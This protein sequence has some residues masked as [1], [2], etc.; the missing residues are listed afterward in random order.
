MH[1]LVTGG[2]GFI[3]SHIVNYY[4]SVSCR[5]TIIDNLSTGT[6]DNISPKA[7]FINKDITEDSW[8]DLLPKDITH[9]IHL[10]AQSSGEISFEDPLY[11]I[12][13][14]A[15]ATLELLNWSLNNKVQKFIFASSMNIYGDVNDELI[16]EDYSINP[17]SF[18]GVGKA[19]SERYIKIFSELGLD[20]VILRLFNIYGPGQNMQ[21]MK[22]GMLSIYCSYVAN[23]DV[24]IVKGSE[25]RFRDFVYIDDV[26]NAV[27]L[28]LRSQIKFDTFNISTGIRTT[29]REALN[30]IFE[31]FDC[32][33]Y[34]Y[35][36]HGG[37]PRD[38]F[39]IY[40]SFEKINKSLGWSPDHNLTIGL[41][42]MIAWL[43]NE[44]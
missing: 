17:T 40:G 8:T 30:K 29:V 34:P 14:N 2:A 21:N 22:Q 15:V 19:A 33:D 42:K 25:E 26:V 16:N 35:E 27:N 36:L 24:V 4:L 9:V 37:T 10:A 11:D 38:Q 6:K 41:K 18:Y 20:S 31:S 1:I 43:R 3:G 44:G 39:G 13:T 28:A 12:R 32:K 23:N 7:F 5:V